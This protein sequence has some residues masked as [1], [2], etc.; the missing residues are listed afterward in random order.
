MFKKYN[1][2][3]E[4]VILTAVKSF[5]IPETITASISNGEPHKDDLV[6]RKIDYDKVIVDSGED[7]FVRIP[8]SELDES[9][10][11]R[12]DEFGFKLNDLG[13]KIST[14]PVVPFRSKGYLLNNVSERYKYA[15]L[16]WMQNIINAKVSW[17]IHENGKPIAVRDVHGAQNILIPNG[18][19]VL[20]KRFSSKE[21]KRRINAGILLKNYLSSDHI[22]I[23]NHVNYI[24]RADGQ[25]TEDEGYGITALLNSKLYNRYFQMT[26]GSTQVNATDINNIP[27]PSLEK[28]RL[29]GSLIKK[30]KENDEIKNE[31]TIFDEL[32]IDKDI[33][34]CFLTT[35]T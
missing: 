20:I 28:I 7:I 26:N 1:V 23:E 21:G 5:E 18:N 29:I 35:F 27:L 3:Q 17:L 10:A 25:L 22:G 12:I 6:V 8:T 15:P 11:T 24:Y 16:I 2:N 34:E 33:L 32:N 4:I 31:K 13:L 9:I 14:G 30:E 19:Y